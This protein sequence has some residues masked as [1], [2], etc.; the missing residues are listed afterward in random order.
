M[1]IL[2]NATKNIKENTIVQS[3]RYDNIDVLKGL[4]IILVL[5]THTNAALSWEGFYTA[6]YMPFF[7]GHP[8][9]YIIIHLGRV[10]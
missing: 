3:K 5:L 8:V 6:F 7:S 2:T 1:Q 10:S 9:T 4:G